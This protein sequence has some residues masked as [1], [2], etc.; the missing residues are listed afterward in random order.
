MQDMTRRGFVGAAGAMAAAAVAGAGISSIPVVR[1]ANADEAGALPDIPA[2]PTETTLPLGG[3]AEAAVLYNGKLDALKLATTLS[4]DQVDAMLLAEPEVTEDYVTAG[5]KTIPAVYVRVRNRFNRCGVGLGSVPAD[6][7]TFFDIIMQEWSEEEA[8]HYLELPMYRWFSAE[9]YA[10]DS[11][12][13]TEEALEICE[14]MAA[15]SLIISTTRAGVKYFAVMAPLWGMWEMNMDKFTAEWCATFNGSLGSDF[16]MGAVN[17]VR[18]VCHIVPVSPDVVDGDMAPY[19]D[20]QETIR[21]NTSFALSPCQCRL[22]RDVS[23]TATCTAEDHPRDT[24]ISVGEAAEYFIECGIGERMTQ[25]EAMAKIQDNIDHGLVVEKLF[26]KKAEVICGCHSDC[27]KL[28][29]TYYALGGVGNMMENISSYTHNYDADT[30]IFCGACV[31][32]SP[33]WPSPWVTTACASWTRSAS[34][35]ASVRWC[36]RSARAACRPSP[37]SSS[38]SCPTT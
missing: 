12:R 38:S 17:S 9:E 1:V 31:D 36:A 26:S 24:C 5:G 21:N 7:E 37:P 22:E 20:W 35:A 23:G 32:R 2:M 11:G 33:W 3:D 25:E 4:S 34:A 29:S 19:T 14:G 6:E 15:H 27:C 30:C 10:A 13:T 28:L 16:A 18:P 8:E